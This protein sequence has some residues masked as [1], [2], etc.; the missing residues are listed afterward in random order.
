MLIRQL[1]NVIPKLCIKVYL[2]LCTYAHTQRGRQRGGKG[3][4]EREKDGER[5][6]AS[7]TG[8]RKRGTETQR[9]AVARTLEIQ[10]VVCVCNKNLTASM[11]IVE[12]NR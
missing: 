8:G 4:A 1:P 9:S 11:Q 12:W 5:E 2:A 10:F 7:E 3:E 6:E